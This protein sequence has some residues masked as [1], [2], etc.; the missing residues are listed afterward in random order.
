M[1]QN[2]ESANLLQE[3]PAD[4]EHLP[5]HVQP[6]HGG[7]LEHTAGRI[8]TTFPRLWLQHQLQGRALHLL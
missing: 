7:L 1:E 6:H 2:C 8:A 5:T 3:L 4:V